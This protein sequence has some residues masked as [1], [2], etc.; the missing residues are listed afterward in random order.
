MFLSNDN[1][2]PIKGR[3]LA[4]HGLESPRCTKMFSESVEMGREDLQV[5]KK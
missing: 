2:G 4:T 5:K 3:T 1:K